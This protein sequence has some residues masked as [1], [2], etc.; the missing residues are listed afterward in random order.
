MLS[1]NHWGSATSS[2]PVLTLLALVFFRGMFRL[3]VGQFG[4]IQDEGYLAAA[5][6]DSPVGVLWQC[7]RYGVKCREGGG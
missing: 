1:L 3:A 4:F 2:S 5:A 6:A 7:A